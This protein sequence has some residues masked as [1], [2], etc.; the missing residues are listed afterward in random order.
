[1][2]KHFLLIL[3][4]VWA[5][6][7][8][9]QAVGPQRETI[10]LVSSILTDT[11][12]LR[13][14]AAQAGKMGAEGSIAILGEPADA[15]VLVRRF[16]S[17]DWRDNVDGR[18]KRDSLP[19]FA[20]EA[21]DAI[22]DAYNAPYS[23]FLTSG[24]LDSLREVAVRGALQAWDT[25]CLRLAT[26][27]K[28]LLRKESAKI[29][30]YTSSLQS[31]YGL[32]DVDTLQKLTGGQCRLLSPVPILINDALTAGARN[33]A[34]WASRPV[35]E[36]RIWENAFEQADRPDATLAVF[37]PEQAMDVRTQLRNILRQYS[38]N[39]LPLDA[40][41]IDDYHVDLSPLQSELSLIR[42]CGTEED[43]A[44]DKML[45]ASFRFF[46]PGEALINTTYGILRSENLF[47]HRIARPVVKYYETAES[48]LG[49][50]VLVEAA[51]SYVQNAYVSNLH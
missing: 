18:A 49:D 3:L 29:L 1:M 36:S 14:L 25:T 47:A 48:E 16:Q 30:I 7:A 17:V 9:K 15:M 41:I 27:H 4:A 11:T 37:T 42:R 46:E 24:A 23:H 26:D 8:C 10:D 31:Q 13:D 44:F 20:G 32:F 50:V 21:F 12:G 43:T 28:A 34:V 35:R 45:P 2:K 33:I 38:V 22:L 51:T 19:D 6:V 5:L 40:L 39:G